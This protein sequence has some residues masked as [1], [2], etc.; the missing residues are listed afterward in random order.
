M[1]TRDREGIILIQDQLKVLRKQLQKEK[2]KANSYLELYTQSSDT[3]EGE[4]ADDLK[5]VRSLN[6][7]EVL[8]RHPR[9]IKAERNPNPND[10]RPSSSSSTQPEEHEPVDLYAP[11]IAQSLS[12]NGGNR[13]SRGPV[14]NPDPASNLPPSHFALSVE[15]AVVGDD[16][17]MQF[18]ARR[19]ELK[20][21][22]DQQV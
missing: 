5:S 2:Q 14:F 21:K 6:F 12:S 20:L 4:N 22:F 17:S 10:R 18:R 8:A 16:G 19:E 11:P 9:W 15:T 3:V 1:L 13:A 7:E